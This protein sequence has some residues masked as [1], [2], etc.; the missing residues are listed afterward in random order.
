MIAFTLPGRDGR[1]ARAA[2]SAMDGS[3]G[4]SFLINRAASVV[5]FCSQ[6]RFRAPKHPEALMEMHFDG[7]D[8]AKGSERLS[9]AI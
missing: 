9:N 4:N 6:V 3:S 1:L 5:S 2:L 8:S 7:G